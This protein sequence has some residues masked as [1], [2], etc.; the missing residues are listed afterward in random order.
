LI[1]SSEQY[2]STLSGFAT[3]DTIDLGHNPITEEF[4]S[5]NTVTLADGYGDQFRFRFVSGIPQGLT[6]ATDAAGDAVL[7]VTCYAEGTRIRTPAGEVAIETL[8]PGDLV[9]TLEGVAKQVRWIGHRR[10][11]CARHPNPESVWPVRVAAHAMGVGL[12]A[13][14]LYLSPDHA[15]YAEG[16]LIPVKHLIDGAAVAQVP[17][18]KVTYYHIE[19]D[20]HAIILAEN[21]P[22]ETYLDT[23]DRA[24]FANGG[25][26]VL[27]RP[28]WCTAQRLREAYSCAPLRATG[29]EVDRVRARLGGTIE[30]WHLAALA[31]NTK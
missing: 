16:V 22:A 23:G 19:L 7:S 20:A 30:S 27:F 10:V 21:L 29:P 28:V 26:A 2:Q 24:S 4:V 11:D 17:R 9:T 5:G 18:A 1:A 15:I 6:L 31:V 8:Q 14:D 25:E 3:G 13:R 12:P